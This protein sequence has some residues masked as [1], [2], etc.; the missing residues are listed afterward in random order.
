METGIAMQSCKREGAEGSLFK[1]VH[2]LVQWHTHTHA[3]THAPTLQLR[4][5][6]RLRVRA[7]QMMRTAMQARASG[8]P[9]SP[10]PYHQWWRRRC[11]GTGQCALF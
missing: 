8:S 5:M 1:S 11:V 7:W 6:R 9:Q 2:T 3:Q 4:L 10:R